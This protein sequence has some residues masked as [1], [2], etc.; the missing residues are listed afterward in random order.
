MA[1]IGVDELCAADWQ[2]NGES[3]EHVVG[4]FNETVVKVWQSYLRIWDANSGKC[5]VISEAKLSSF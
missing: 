3:C 5:D 2:R 1:W 4:H